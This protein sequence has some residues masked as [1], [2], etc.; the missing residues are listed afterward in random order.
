MYVQVNLRIHRVVFQY[1]P[2]QPLSFPRSSSRFAQR[3]D[4]RKDWLETVFYTHNWLS[5][6]NVN[7][8]SNS[9]VFLPVEVFCTYQAFPLLIQQSPDPSDAIISKR[10]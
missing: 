9:A 6:A 4:W 2:A 3:S 5:D 10:I 7:H 8:S 1:G